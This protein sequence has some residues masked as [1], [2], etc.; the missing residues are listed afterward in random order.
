MYVGS[1]KEGILDRWVKRSS[2][3]CSVS[4]R[5]CH[6]LKRLHSTH[7]KYVPNIHQSAPSLLESYLA[8]CKVKRYQCAVF[9]LYDLDTEKQMQ[10]M[11]NDLVVHHNLTNMHRG[12]N[13]KLP[14]ER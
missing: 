4:E 12:L 13:E 2:S 8:L 7:E 14:S 11:E 1:A 3:H 6:H 5:L 9:V 10:D